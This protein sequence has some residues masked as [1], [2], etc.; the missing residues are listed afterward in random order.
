MILTGWIL[1]F[2]VGLTLGL[3]GAGGSILTLPILVYFLDVQPLTAT[4][5]SLLIVGATACIGALQ[6]QRKGLVNFRAVVTFTP[7]AMV[8]VWMARAYLIPHLPH[9]VGGISIQTLCMLLF[10]LFMILTALFMRKPLQASSSSSLS[11]RILS[12]LCVGG[13]TGTVGAGG[14]FLIIPTLLTFYQISMQEAVG[15]SLAIITLNCLTGFGG[16][17]FGGIS[18]DW[19]F[20]AIIIALAAVGMWVGILFSSRVQP[21]KIKQLFSLFLLFL[22]TSI[23]AEEI[24]T[25]HRHKESSHM[26]VQ[27]F[28]DKA[29]STFTYVVADPQ[30]QK[31]AVIDSVLDYDPFSG[32]LSTSSADGVIAY[33]EKENLETEWILETHA[34]ADHLTASQYLKSKLGGK[35]AIGEHIKEVLT[36]WVPR[37]NLHDIPLDG[38]QFDHLFKEG[39]QF[40]IGT[41]EAEVFYTPGHTSACISYHIENAVFAGDTLFVPQIGTARTDFPG[42]SAEA[43]YDSTQKLLSLPNST[44]IYACHDYPEKEGGERAAVTVEEHKAENSMVHEGVTKEEYVAARNA[45]DVKKAPPKLILPALQFNLRA[46]RLNPTEENGMTYFKIPVRGDPGLDSL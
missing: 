18:F 27:T 26:Q 38:S 45:K 17:L 21:A 29:T 41:L 30:T 43:M 10:A 25:F 23:F 1:L 46:G 28:F 12:S 6:Y 32:K 40:K 44:V 3:L 8:G 24:Y 2:F 36:I 19:T 14:G 15:T 33:I 20:L 37:Y 42:G 39:D 35:I 31:C 9:E 5:Y 7:P 13:V 34:H 16:M 11:A 22:G 4:N